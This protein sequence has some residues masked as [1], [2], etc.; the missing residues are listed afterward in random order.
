MRKFFSLATVYIA[1][2]CSLVM[3]GCQEQDPDIFDRDSLSFSISIESVGANDVTVD[4]KH[5]GDMD[6]TYYAFC[7][8]DF[9]LGE[10]AAVREKVQELQSL[11]EDISAL[12]TSG[13]ETTVVCS[14]LQ[15]SAK[16]RFVV[17][18][19]DSGF[20]VYGTP[21]SLYFDTVEGEVIYEE[22][23]DW[24]V[25]YEGKMASSDNAAYGDVIQVITTDS[26]N[27]YF[28]SAFPKSRLDADG[29]KACIEDAVAVQEAIF[30]AWED[31]GYTVDR[32]DYV[33]RTTAG[34][35]FDLDEDTEYVGV[36]I[37]VDDDFIPTGLYALSDPFYPDETEYSTAY[38]AWLGDWTMSGTYTDV[39]GR[40]RTV[41]YDV[42]IDCLVP[43]VSFTVSGYQ[44]D[45]VN[46]MPDITAGFDSQTGCLVFSGAFVEEAYMD[47][48]LSRIYFYG[49]RTEGNNLSYLES[50]GP[51]ANAAMDSASSATV[52]A[53][54]Q[55]QADGTQFIPTEM[56]FLA[57][58][59]SGWM[60]F[61]SPAP[62]FPFTMEKNN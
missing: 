13:T 37:G 36:A 34:Y 30:Q 58:T 20:N 5:N 14:G 31:E 6:V 60:T 40:V 4:V 51:V 38:G 39:S 3:A 42:T 23:P 22:N 24:T 48:V 52:Y 43:D 15:S 2:A 26:R 61:A 57:R 62:Q 25:T 45:G 1:A 59:I 21:A 50:E 10:S 12:L 44:Y 55:T 11:G 16:Y 47:N 35:L 9:T 49:T 27:G 54:S 7:Y 56:Q 32:S 29:V 18:G 28:A 17:F 53:V 41:E 19:L 33:Y 46:E 8:R